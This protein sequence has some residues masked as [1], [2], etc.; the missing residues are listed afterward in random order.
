MCSNSEFRAVLQ[1]SHPGLQSQPLWHRAARLSALSQALHR[2]LQ[3]RE[4]HQGDGHDPAQVEELHRSGDP[5]QLSGH[6]E[7]GRRSIGAV[8]PIVACPSGAVSR[9][10]RRRPHP[11]Q[12]LFC[13]PPPVELD[14]PAE[15]GRADAPTQ[16]EEQFGVQGHADTA[17]G[18]GRRRLDNFKE[19]LDEVPKKQ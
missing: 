11:L 16:E 6:D 4:E 10:Q 7:P 9:G 1:A 5:A 8:Q 14:Q 3:A 19:Y 17:R 15:P 2:P 12:R 13:R 18:T